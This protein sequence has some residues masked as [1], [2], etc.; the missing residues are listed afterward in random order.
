MLTLKPGFV[1]HCI[2]SASWAELD[3]TVWIGELLIRND[4]NDDD[5]VVPELSATLY[6]HSPPPSPLVVATAALKAW[7][8]SLKRRAVGSFCKAAFQSSTIL[9]V[10]LI[11][12]ADFLDF[13]ESFWPSSS[14]LSSSLASYKQ[15]N[16]CGKCLLTGSVLKEK[17][18]AKQASEVAPLKYPQETTTPTQTNTLAVCHVATTTETHDANIPCQYSVFSTQEAVKCPQNRP[19]I[20]LFNY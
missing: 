9:S 3:L 4:H 16:M 12:S 7:V 1:W 15:R 14:T 13:F 8:T 2:P 17:H 6:R 5:D 18:L 10:T 19:Y 20:T 11:A